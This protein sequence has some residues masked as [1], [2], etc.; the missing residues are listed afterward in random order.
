MRYAGINPTDIVCGTG[1]G[2]AIYV[3]GCDFHCPGCFNPQTWSFSGGKTWD[4]EQNQRFLNELSKPYIKRLSILGGEPLHPK[5]LKGVSS[6]INDAD[7][8]KHLKKW[9]F[10]GY[11]WEE[12]ISDDSEDGILRKDILNRIDYLVEGRFIES[13][14]DVTLKFRGSSNQR[15][16]DV[17]RTIEKG[18]IVTI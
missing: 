14:R 18:E 10:S 7:S 16:I 4:S 11:T 12:I 15:I 6:I 3:Q 1:V 9:V 5:N 2:I 8:V 13:L 17:K